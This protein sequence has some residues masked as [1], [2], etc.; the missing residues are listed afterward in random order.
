MLHRACGVS[1]GQQESSIL[2]RRKADL[3]LLQSKDGSVGIDMSDVADWAAS[4][5]AKISAAID[6]VGGIAALPNYSPASTTSSSS[7][8]GDDAAAALL[9]YG[10]SVRALVLGVPADAALGINHFMRVADSQVYSGMMRGTQ[11]VVEEVARAGSPTDRECLEYVLSARAGSSATRFPNGVRDCDDAT[12]RVRADRLNANGEGM[13]LA[14]FVAHP[15][16][17]RAGLSEAHCLALR[18]YTTAAFASLNTPLR[19]I[20]RETPHPFP[21]TIKFIAEAIKQLRAVG[22]SGVG[23]HDDAM[24]LWRGLRDMAVDEDAEFLKA[25]GTE[26][27]PMSTTTSLAVALRYSASSLCVLL[28]LK[29][30]SFMQR[31]ADLSYIS[32]FPGEAEVLYPP[33]TFLQVLRKHEVTSEQGASFTV[34]EVVPHLGS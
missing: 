30:T 19:E 15:S 8:T 25:G 26:L 4:L 29:T 22:S 23:A 5:R 28:R 18:L 14:D 1:Y 7:N 3:A 33:L 34:I 10:T 32:C 9:R 27:A 31:G 17:V 16:S 11:A 24:D 21:V 6:E 13:S 20:E 12:G 2:L